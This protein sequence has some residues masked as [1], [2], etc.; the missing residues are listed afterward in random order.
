MTFSRVDDPIEKTLKTELQFFITHPRSAIPSTSHTNQ[1]QSNLEG[2][3]TGC[4]C[5]EVG[6]IKGLLGPTLAYLMKHLS[7]AWPIA[8]VPPISWLLFGIPG[9]LE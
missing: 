6:I 7:S 4:E 9:T 3:Y 2:E 8:A 5:Q 1:P